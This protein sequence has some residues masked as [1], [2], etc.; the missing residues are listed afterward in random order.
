MSEPNV[1]FH[2]VRR[3]SRFCDLAQAINTAIIYRIHS[4][5]QT[6][7]QKE[8]AA[9][10]PATGN[11][12]A[13]T[14]HTE[15]P[16]LAELLNQEAGLS[17]EIE[18]KVIRNEIIDYTYQ[19]GGNQVTTQKLQVN[20]QSKI[21]NQYCLGV[22]KMKGKDKNE[23]KQF[24]ERWQTGT[25]WRFKAIKLFNDKPAYINTPC[26]IVLDLRKSQAQALLQSTSFPLAPVPTVTIA[27]VLQLEQMQRF[28]LMA[29]PAKILEARASG[30]GMQIAD[31]RLV[32][33]SKQKNSTSTEYASLP[34]TWFFKKATELTSF[35]SCIG[36]KPLLFMCLTGNSKDGQVQVTT[37]KNHSWWQEAAGPKCLAMAEEAATM[38]GDNAALRDVA[39]LKSFSPGAS[40][41]YI[42]PMAT[43]TACQLVDPTCSSPASIL[44]EATEH[45]YQLNHVYVELPNKQDNLKTKDD[46]L[47]ARLDVWD[48][49]KK[50]SL[51]FRGKAMLQLASLADDQANEYEHRLAN[52]E[53]RHPLLASL[54]LHLQNKPRKRESETNPTEFSQTQSDNVLSAVVVEAAPST[55][56]D[57]PNDSVQAIHGLLAGSTQTSERLA[58]TS[59]DKL[60]PSPFYN[61]LADGKPV[62]KALTLLHFTQRGNG[63]QH[64]N[65][66]RIIT[67]RVRDPTADA[68][69]ELTNENCYATVALC[70]V[71]KI[72]DF[73]TAKDA[74]AIAVI[75]KVVAPSNPQ[76]HAADLYI[77]AMEVVLKQDI[78]RSVEMMRKLVLISNT[79]SANPATSSEVAWQQKKCRRL[80]RYPTLT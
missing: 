38:C 5:K 42:S 43:L 70:T 40:V 48:Y 66:F 78:H 58:A 68:A 72:T 51:A 62:H 28:D 25:T 10:K 76:Q 30:T 14:E 49:S 54:R 8:G 7:A 45:L 34:L 21:P 26:R 61:M 17:S 9:A 20:L 75:S 67:E 12:S 52:D 15:E 19:W 41:D 23:L 4:P 59:L 33:G 39:A 18:L 64:A 56:T 24:A 11:D 47:F 3:P 69:T 16:Q 63:K 1:S 36:K 46:R 53:L 2:F 80:L 77:E 55:F 50:I 65:G 13:A 44:G 37:I 60:K 27:D 29:I 57:I 79:Q 6:M 32:D 31:V 35:K 22:V 73:S 71:E 74:V